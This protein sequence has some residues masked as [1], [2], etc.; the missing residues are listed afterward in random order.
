MKKIFL[1]LI[2][3]LLISQA[4]IAGFPVGKGRFKVVPNYTLYHAEGYWDNSGV[5]KAYVNNGKFTSNYFGIYFAAGLDR[6]LDFIAV[7]PFV[8]QTESSTGK[9]NSVG[10]IGDI[11]LGLSY[12]LN[13]NSHP[14]T[15][16]SLSGSLIIPGY[17]NVDTPYIGF[18]NFGMEAK[19]SI[20]GSTDKYYR[21]PYF[22]IDLGLRQYFDV[23][24]PS[25]IFL[26]ITGGMPLSEQVKIS[27]TFNSV[28]SISTSSNFSSSNLTANKNFSYTRATAAVG[29]VASPRFEV[30]FSIFHDI[31]GKNIGRGSGLGLYAVI[32][33]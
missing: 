29:F 13:N 27:G 24:G 30:W 14:N 19:F 2:A 32:K 26:N 9:L 3:V 5:Y 7:L 31:S 16:M 10:N 22:D 6:N 21:N 8:V 33:L 4:A 17:Q 18:G 1:F 12:F 23:L 28:N 25:Q 15:H 20:A 11:S